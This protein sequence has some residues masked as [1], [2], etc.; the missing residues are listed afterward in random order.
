MDMNQI[1]N[2]DIGING[3][4]ID[5]DV[6]S[7][8][9]VVD[10]DEYKKAF[11]AVSHATA[12]VLK[13]TLGP[14]GRT[15]VIDDGSSHYITK[16]GWSI[17]N[18]LGFGQ[19][20]YNTLYSFIKDASYNLVE[21]VG[22]GTTTV[23]V[24]ADEFIH[25][26]ENDPSFSKFRQRDI[27]NMLND[28]K[29]EIIERLKSPKYL[30]EIDKEG[31]FSDIR[32][33]AFTSTNENEEISDMIQKIYQ[34]THNPTIYVNMGL[35][36]ESSYSIVNGYQL[37]CTPRGLEEFINTDDDKYRTMDGVY[38]FFCN[39]NMTYVDHYHV[40]RRLLSIQEHL[41]SK[42]GVHPSIIVFAP[43][44]DE[45]LAGAIESRARTYAQNRLIPPLMMVQC[46]MTNSYL[47]D[48]FADAAVVTNSRIFTPND[49]E[50]LLQSESGK[51]KRGTDL[52]DPDAAMKEII[53]DCMGKDQFI[54]AF[55][56]SISNFT[57]TKT[58][59][60]FADF[61]TEL[62]RYQVR[63]REVQRNYEETKSKANKVITMLDKDMMHANL[64]YIRFS[65]HMGTINVGGGSEAE[66]RCL[67][68]SVDDAVLSCRSAYENG[69]VKGMNL[70]TIGAITDYKMD[71]AAQY[72]RVI[73]KGTDRHT[74][75]EFNLRVAVVTA[76]EKVFINVTRAIMRNKYPE[77]TDT[78]TLDWNDHTMTMDQVIHYAVATNQGFNIVTDKLEDNTDLHVT[79]SVICDIEVLSACISILSHVLTSNQLL[80]VNRVY[81][82]SLQN[83]VKEYKARQ[84]ARIF[85]EEVYNVFKDNLPQYS[86]LP[87]HEILLD[88]DKDV[89][90]EDDATE[91]KT[92][93]TKEMIHQK[94]EAISSDFRKYADGITPK[95]VE[96]IMKK[97]NATIHD[98]AELRKNGIDAAL[99]I[100][101]D[102][103]LPHK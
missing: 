36:K 78:D 79:N 11:T 103:D 90:Y 12:E 66:K 86:A 33:I 60:I 71:L 38:T 74:A 22:D 37:D 1:M 3:L 62:Q 6:K 40:I 4:T 80:S 68:D 20:L 25:Q 50:A 16:D 23:I 92:E 72:D 97:S 28:V 21:K 14:F 53:P 27:L 45:A 29:E 99:Y 52:E 7:G 24:A 61:N 32:R 77:L 89:V 70:A 39:H 31:D 69:Y 64:R 8:L 35:E 19:P 94:A 13:N 95:D 10:G 17:V 54:S 41:A 51:D 84:S 102:M 82:T 34:E 63:F 55:L 46:G 65:G 67:K 76:L 49:L 9:N 30:H 85:A 101:S 5:E 18:R 57:A 93:K 81:D 56:G 26:I 98:P 43:Y 100:T 58:H 15:T 91:D 59:V 96:E 42:P 75:E 88:R 73:S 2:S 44:F 48:V 83:R 47:K 87:V